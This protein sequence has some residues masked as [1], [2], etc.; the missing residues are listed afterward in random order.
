MHQRPPADAPDR[1]KGGGG[2]EVSDP[3]EES[4]SNCAQRRGWIRTRGRAELVAR[5]ERPPHAA[6]VPASPRIALR[7]GLRA[8]PAQTRPAASTLDQFAAGPALART[9]RNSTGSQARFSNGLFF[10]QLT[11]TLGPEN[12]TA[13]LRRSFF[14][15]FPGVNEGNHSRFSSSILSMGWRWYAFLHRY[16]RAIAPL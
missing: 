12:S 7:R 10:G 15:F 16:I 9:R 14:V 4:C 1:A 2:V 3:H 5:T 13:W 6:R 11:A 8:L